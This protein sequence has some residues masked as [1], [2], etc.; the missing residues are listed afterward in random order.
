MVG[1]IAR[2][3]AHEF[4]QLFI[5]EGDLNSVVWS[6]EPG[7]R[8]TFNFMVLVMHAGSSTD[9]PTPVPEAV[10]KLIVDSGE[11]FEKGTGEDVPT[12]GFWFWKHSDP[13][14]IKYW[15]MKNRKSIW[16]MLYGS[17]SPPA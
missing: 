15:L 2:E 1:V 12:K 11:E 6:A 4:N 7:G 3:H 9:I 10:D 8:E 13:D 5:A 17:I 16:A 14:K